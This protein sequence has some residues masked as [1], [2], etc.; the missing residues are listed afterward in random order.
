MNEVADVKG[1][2]K[3]KSRNGR[4]KAGGRAQ[5]TARRRR[6]ISLAPQQKQFMRMIASGMTRQEIAKANGTCI[7]SVNDMAKRIIKNLGARN[8][9]HAVAIVMK[10]R[11]A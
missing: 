7:S 3:A 4:R 6:A 10:R 9:P 1:K 5:K 8:F 2:V 11:M